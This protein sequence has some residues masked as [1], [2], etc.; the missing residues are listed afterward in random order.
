MENNFIETH[1]RI[2]ESGESYHSNEIIGYVKCVKLC[3][4]DRSYK[5]EG[6]IGKEYPV[7]GTWIFISEKSSCHIGSPWGKNFIPINKKF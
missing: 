6:E 7:R 1:K 2:L 5:T 4:S 3:T